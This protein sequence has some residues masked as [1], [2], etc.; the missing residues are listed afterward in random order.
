MEFTLALEFTFSSQLQSPAKTHII[1]IT[2]MPNTANILNSP[3]KSLL[4]GTIFSSKISAN[5]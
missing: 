1:I 3:D 5:L 2:I 4:Q